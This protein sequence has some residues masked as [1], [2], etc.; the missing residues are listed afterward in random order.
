MKNYINIMDKTVFAIV[1]FCALMLPWG[2]LVPQAGTFLV[3]FWLIGFNWKEKWNNI[4]N[5]PMI[6][7]W[8]I[9]AL[10]HLMGYF[11]SENKQ[12]AI[13]SIGVKLGLFL[14]PLVFASMRF[15]DNQSK[16]IMQAFLVG[17][18]AVGIFLA[19]R[20]LY[21][22]LS[23]GVNKWTYQEFAR[24]MM[25]PSYLSLYYVAGIMICFHGILLR[26]VP[27]IKKALASAFVLFFT[28]IILLLASKTGIISLLTVFVFYIGY[29]VVR[30]K[31]YVV[32]GV[33]FLALIAAFIISL[34]LFPVLKSRLQVM[35]DVLVSPAPIDPK[36]AESNRVRILIWQ[37][38]REIIAEHPWTGVGTGGVQDALMVKYAERGMTGAY[39]KKL[40]AHSQYFQTGIALGLPG[41]VILAGMFLAGFITSVRNRFGFGALLTVLLV[42]N[43]IPESMLQLQAGTLFV[44]FFYSL[45]LFSID[46][47]LLS[48]SG[49]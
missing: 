20:A 47:K 43:F 12:E 27:M 11:W 17:L 49:S 45:V 15:N 6:W 31:R 18:S 41:L 32:A 28:I 14:F 16:R 3:F 42:F 34:Q 36:D 29:A 5:M 24:D 13:T 26:N 39:E 35:K 30:F 10:L 48:P 9:F 4:R 19:V 40:N 8:I 22:D 37:I 2:F 25:H 23:Q 33:A 46:R 21:Y 38:D 7:L 44:G 1:L